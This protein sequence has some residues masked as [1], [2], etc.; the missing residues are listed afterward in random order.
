M[1]SVLAPSLRDRLAAELRA[2]LG[3]RSSTSSSHREHHSHGESW[4][5]PAE[6]DIVVFPTSTDEVCGIVAAAA[7]YGAP[8]VPLAPARRSKGT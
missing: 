7:R 6:P 4:H 1:P 3:D 2:L 8:I 5:P